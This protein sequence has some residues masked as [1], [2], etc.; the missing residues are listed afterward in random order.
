[1]RREGPIVSVSSG[2][3]LVSLGHHDSD[4]GGTPLERRAGM[5]DPIDRRA[6][7]G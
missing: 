4:V 7:E 3:F 2:V 5:F 6:R 1:M